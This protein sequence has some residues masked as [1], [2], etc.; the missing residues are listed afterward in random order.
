LVAMLAELLPED[1]A[2]AEVLRDQEQVQNYQAE[3]F[4]HVAILFADESLGPLEDQP[5]NNPFKEYD[6]QTHNVVDVEGLL[7][8]H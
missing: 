4:L 7:Q 1:V 6:G 2:E 8:D 3:V 5:V